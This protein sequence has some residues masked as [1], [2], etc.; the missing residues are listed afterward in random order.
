MIV[1]SFVRRFA[2]TLAFLGLV[3]AGGI[4]VPAQAKW[5]VESKLGDVKPDEKVVPAHPRPVQVLFEFQRDGTPNPKATKIIAPW[6]MED[7][8]G[9]GVFS[10]VAVTPATDGAVL[11]IKFNNVVDKAELDKAKKQG[12]S[13]GL[14]FGMFG[15]VVATDHYQVTLTYVSAT[16]AAP[17]STMVEHALIMKYGKSEVEVPGFEVK[18]GD[19]AVKT[20][21]R[22]ALARG[23]NTIATDPAFPK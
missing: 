12:F 18:N 6:A 10:D 15:G 19:E 2:A 23:I 17:I 5:Y 11:S 1:R 14:G 7:V 16:G 3:V 8:K 13:A 9:T 4:A 21:V 20:V 22:Q